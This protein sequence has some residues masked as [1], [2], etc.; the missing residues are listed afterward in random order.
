MS[1]PESVGVPRPAVESAEMDA[2]IPLY[3]ASA[4]TGCR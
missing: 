1:Q 3:T 4:M 2:P